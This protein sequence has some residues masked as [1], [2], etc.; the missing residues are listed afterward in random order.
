VP[1]GVR[2]LAERLYAAYNRHDAQAAAGLY[3]AGGRHE[4]IAQGRVAEGRDE[5]RDGLERLFT[6]F[7]DVRWEPVRTIADGDTT[8]VE[9]VMSGTLQAKLGPFQPAGQRLTLRGIHVVIADGHEIAA[10]LDYWD[11]GTFFK[12]M[13][14]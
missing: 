2:E 5:I 6:S 14:A 8:A 9:Y 11:S 13:K 3:A 7:P 10:T 12:Q 1:A 4:E